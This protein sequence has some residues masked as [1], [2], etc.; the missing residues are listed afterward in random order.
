M[1]GK[2]RLESRDVNR[3]GNHQDNLDVEKHIDDIV[4]VT[5]PKMEEKGFSAFIARGTTLYAST[6]DNTVEEEH[7][8]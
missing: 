8:G 7:V 2:Y 1:F 3:L 5:D 6:D 4:S